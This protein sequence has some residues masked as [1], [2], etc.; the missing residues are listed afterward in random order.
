MSDRCLKRSAGQE[1]GRGRCGEVG[2]LSRARMHAPRL[3]KRVSCTCQVT[4]PV[5]AAV[6]AAAKKALDERMTYIMRS[7]AREM[8][9]LWSDSCST[10]SRHL[11][12]AKRLINKSQTNECHCS[13]QHQ[14]TAPPHLPASRVSA[15]LCAPSTTPA[16]NL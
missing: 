3:L 8:R 5:V 2:G 4:E 1:S 16:T 11:D 6:A 13:L 10:C 14:R 12:R 9:L 15:I 7:G